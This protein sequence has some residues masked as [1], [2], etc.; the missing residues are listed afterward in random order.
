MRVER[1]ID[2]VGPETAGLLIDVCCHLKGLERVERERQWP[3]RSAK[4][5]LR[6]G[7]EM[8]ARHY[9]PDGAGQR[10]TRSGGGEGFRPDLACEDGGEKPR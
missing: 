10:R 7:L 8:L 1:A 9:T 3:Q 2:S 5:L 4:L 6:A